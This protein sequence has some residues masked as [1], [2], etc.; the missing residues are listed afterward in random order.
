MLQVPKLAQREGREVQ[1]KD[2]VE[3]VGN[4]KARMIKKTSQNSKQDKQI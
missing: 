3:V 4:E 1:A 2:E